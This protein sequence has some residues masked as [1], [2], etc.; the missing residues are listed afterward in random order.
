VDGGV[1]GLSQRV[2]VLAVSAGHSF[3]AGAFSFF[4]AVVWT[5][6]R[7][8]DR[9]RPAASSRLKMTGV[10]LVVVTFVQLYLGALVAGLRAGAR[11]QYM[12]GH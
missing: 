7:L 3:G 4:A 9:P 11:L 1:R 2:E 12:A 5:L 8:A 10:A 6:R